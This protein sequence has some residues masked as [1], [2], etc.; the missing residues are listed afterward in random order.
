MDS[1]EERNRRGDWRIEEGR[2]GLGRGLDRN[3]EWR[4]GDQTEKR[5]VRRGKK[6]KGRRLKEMK[7]TKERR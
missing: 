7:E 6:R 2:E 5:I 1:K 3:E 4:K